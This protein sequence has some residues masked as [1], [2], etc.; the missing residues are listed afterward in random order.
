MIFLAIS[1]HN[2]LLSLVAIQILFILFI[3]NSFKQDGMLTYKHSTVLI[4][5]Q[6]PTHDG[7]FPW[8]FGIK[9]SGV[10]EEWVWAVCKNLDLEI[11][12]D[13]ETSFF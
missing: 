3:L 2:H 8:G 7:I 10:Q 12:G 9:L 6:T 11:I 4:L 1:Y 5:F 13:L